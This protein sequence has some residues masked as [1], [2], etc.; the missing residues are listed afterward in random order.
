M[1]DE[2]VY[3]L[4]LSFK[5]SLTSS[6]PLYFQICMSFFKEMFSSQPDHSLSVY[7]FSQGFNTCFLNPDSILFVF[8]LFVL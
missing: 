6:K 3:P 8:F 5:L 4:F 2:S 7:I 1:V